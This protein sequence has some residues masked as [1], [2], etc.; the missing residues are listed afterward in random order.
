M[1]VA[2]LSKLGTTQ[3]KRQLGFEERLDAAVDPPLQNHAVVAA[4]VVPVGAVLAA[5]EVAPDDAPA[6]P[7]AGEEEAADE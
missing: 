7:A 5:A 6:A 3:Q 4:D 2:A 1:E